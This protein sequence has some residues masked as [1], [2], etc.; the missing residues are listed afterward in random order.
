MKSYKE[1]DKQIIGASDIASLIFV[2]PGDG[3]KAEVIDYAGDGAYSAYIVD[4]DAVIGENYELTAEFRC[5]LK[6]YDDEQKTREFHANSI[7]VY[8]AGG[9]GTIIRLSKNIK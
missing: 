5:W 4:D 9:Y 3:L 8:R 6:I 1:Y 7:Q 2:G